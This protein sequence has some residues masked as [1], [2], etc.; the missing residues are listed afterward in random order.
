MIIFWKKQAARLADQIRF[1][2]SL[3]NV[4]LNAN[5]ALQ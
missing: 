1:L 5:D 4:G 2:R 3:V